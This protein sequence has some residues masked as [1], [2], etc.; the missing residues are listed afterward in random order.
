MGAVMSYARTE[1]LLSVENVSLSYGSNLILRDINVKIDNLIR[2]ELAND[3]TGQIIAFLGPSGI[4][5]TQFLR[6][7]A[8]LQK[9]TTG[10]VYLGHGRTPVAPGLVGMV[11][12]QYYLY[13]NRTV[14]SNLMVSVKQ[15]GCNEKNGYEKCM[16]ML[17]RFDLVNKAELYPA[18]LSGGQRQRV[19]IA[20]QL[21][22]S[23]HFLLMDEP[24]A[25]LD[26]KNKN[27]VA[28]LVQ[29]VAN[30]DDLNT[31][32]MVTHDIP[33][34]LAIADTVWIM[35]RERDVA[36]NEIPGARIVDTLDMIELGF[37]WHPDVKRM[38]GFIDLVREIEDRF[39]NR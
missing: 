26:V 22:C 20:Q 38:P 3:V 13:R 19:A 8:G 33:S 34:A 2:P 14:M 28:K 23:E 31:I 39:E 10:N 11:S 1:T 37:M 7:L 16:E 24:T 6:I 17:N 25:G 36:G 4:G 35:D 27:R 18:Q 29:E 5:K 32:I 12:Q 9:P 15:T 30:Q 21:L